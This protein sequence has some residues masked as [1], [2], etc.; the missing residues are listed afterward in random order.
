MPPYNPVRFEFRFSPI[1]QDYVTCLQDFFYHDR[2][3]WI[4]LAAW[5]VVTL[6]IS[7]FFLIGTFGGLFPGALVF[8]IP[9]AFLFYFVTGP[10]RVGKQAK[11]YSIYT[12][13]V[14]WLITDRGVFIKNRE[15]D[16]DLPWDEFIR[17]REITDHYLLFQKDNPRI[18]QFLPKRV[19]EGPQQE[20]SFRELLRDKFQ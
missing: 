3:T 1:P 18:F 4:I 14:S 8:I 12:S 11:K 2:R 13:E 17:A 15:E 5:L 9:L 20:E 6:V 7:Y 10:S 19:F 16:V